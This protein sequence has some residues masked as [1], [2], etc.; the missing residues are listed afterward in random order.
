MGDILDV[1]EVV[2]SSN[3]EKC[4][5]ILHSWRASNQITPSVHQL[6]VMKYK[7]NHR[8]NWTWCNDLMYGG[9]GG[10]RLTTITFIT[11]F[12]FFQPHFAT[13]SLPPPTARWSTGPS[14]PVSGPCSASP[15][16]G[17]SSASSP[18]CWST[19]YS[20]ELEK[21]TDCQIH[22]RYTDLYCC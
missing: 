15:S 10:G 11:W 1:S 9:C 3:G 6:R 16:L 2:W 17:S 19:R 18:A 22:C 13:C 7:E 5:A 4:W 8:L 14:T 12:I 20:G 21:I